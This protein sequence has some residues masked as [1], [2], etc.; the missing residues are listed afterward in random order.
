MRQFYVTRPPT[1][2]LGKIKCCP[3]GFSRVSWNSP[4]VSRD[5]LGGSRGSPGGARGSD[6]SS[7]S[8]KIFG[9]LFRKLLVVIQSTNRPIFHPSSIGSIP[10]SSEDGHPGSPQDNGISR[11]LL[12]VKALGFVFSSFSSFYFYNA[13]RRT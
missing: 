9:S 3:S 4:W 7:L 8:V 1:P 12:D 6:S 2:S 13:Q 5:R 11:P 10:G